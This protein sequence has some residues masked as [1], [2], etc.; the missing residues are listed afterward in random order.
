VSYSLGKAWRD[1]TTK[2][3]F[4]AVTLSVHDRMVERRAA[5]C[6]FASATTLPIPSSPAS[7]CAR[8]EKGLTK[9]LYRQLVSHVDEC[10]FGLKSATREAGSVVHGVLVDVGMIVLFPKGRRFQGG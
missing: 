8:T 4:T 1:L 9:D 10:L 6:S 3:L 2:D 5:P 7:L